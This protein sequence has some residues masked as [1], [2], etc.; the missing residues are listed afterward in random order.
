MADGGSRRSSI[1]LACRGSRAKAGKDAR[2]FGHVPPAFAAVVVDGVTL[3]D[4][5]VLEDPNA[6]VYLV[7]DE[8]QCSGVGNFRR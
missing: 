7:L 1:A 2:A 4:D 3:H 6:V 8:D 5:E